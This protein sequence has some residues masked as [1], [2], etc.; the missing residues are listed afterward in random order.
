LPRKKPGLVPTRPTPSTT[1]LE[2]RCGRR[3]SPRATKRLPLASE[4]SEAERELKATHDAEAE[5][6]AKS[7]ARAALPRAPSIASHAYSI[8]CLAS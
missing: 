4:R 7:D 2:R 1:T 6:K 3:W 5:T 8:P